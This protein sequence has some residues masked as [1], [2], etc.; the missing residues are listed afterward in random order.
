MDRIPLIQTL[1]SIPKFPRR[2]MKGNQ[3]LRIATT[4]CAYVIQTTV[5]PFID[6]PG[7]A[8]SG[9]PLEA[10]KRLAEVTAVP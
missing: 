6:K 10:A 8:D 3:T 1:I 2:L 4:A 7:D 9:F 5:H